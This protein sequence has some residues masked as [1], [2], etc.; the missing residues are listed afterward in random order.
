MAPIFL[1]SIG[2]VLESSQNFGDIPDIFAPCRLKEIKKFGVKSVI[3]S[4][5][6]HTNFSTWTFIAG[7]KGTT[8]NKILYCISELHEIFEH[9]KF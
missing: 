5:F 6:E 1:S 2:K 9:A 4:K 7:K 8:R 3:L